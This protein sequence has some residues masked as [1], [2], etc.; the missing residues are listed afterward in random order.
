MK[1]SDLNNGEI[2]IITGFDEGKTFKNKMAQLNI[3][4]G[5]EIKKVV[6]EPFKGPV[7]I[8]VDNTRAAIGQGIANKILVKKK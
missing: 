6:S 8:M 3:R 4:Q 1:L 7:I 2:G 5:K